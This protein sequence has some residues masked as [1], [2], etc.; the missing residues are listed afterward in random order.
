M[1]LKENLFVQRCLGE[2]ISWNAGSIHE[3]VF[4]NF[5]ILGKILTKGSFL[6]QYPQTMSCSITPKEISV[7]CVNQHVDVE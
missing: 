5:I 6:R 7:Q 3:T 1:H 2:D 4:S